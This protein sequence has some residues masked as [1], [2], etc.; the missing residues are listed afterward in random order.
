MAEIVFITGTNTG[1]G[2]TLLTA[3]MLKHL[4]NTGCRALAMKPFA[5]GHRADAELLAAI[6]D[7]ELPIDVVNPYPY[8]KPI[9]PWVAAREEGRLIQLKRAVER[10]QVV[11]SACEILLIEGCGGLMSP[12]GPGYT[13]LELIAGLKTAVIVVARSELGVLNHTLLT[14]AALRGCDLRRVAVALMGSRRRDISAETNQAA[15]TELAA[16]TPV[17]AVPYLGP[18]AATVHGVERSA[19]AL[20]R[21]LKKTLALTLGSDRLSCVASESSSGTVSKKK[22]KKS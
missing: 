8:K 4:R 10:V 13:N 22:S 11:R 9:A 18:R 7:Q 5:T 15:L 17:I 3:L 19:P 6:Q 2:K 1:V 14:L 20:E 12:L 21:I 16:P